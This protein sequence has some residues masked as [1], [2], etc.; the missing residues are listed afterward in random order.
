M[1][2][3]GRKK[4]I[5]KKSYTFFIDFSIQFMYSICGHTYIT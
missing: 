3:L 5:Y 2:T 4:I 1:D